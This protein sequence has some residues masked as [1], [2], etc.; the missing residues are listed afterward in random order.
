MSRLTKE[1]LF[2]LAVFMIA[3]RI[4]VWMGERDLLNARYR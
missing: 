3:C 2:I 1:I 4:F